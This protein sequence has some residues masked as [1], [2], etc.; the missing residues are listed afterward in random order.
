LQV[1]PGNPDA[2]PAALS[3]IRTKQN[4]AN[5]PILCN[6]VHN[7]RVIY[8][9]QNYMIWHGLFVPGSKE[10]KL[11]AVQIRPKSNMGMGYCQTMTIVHWR[12]T[13]FILIRE[14][15]NLHIVDFDDLIRKS[16][17]YGSILL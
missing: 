5:D 1:L 9:F 7:D 10:L 14:T 13:D 12:T 6:L 3:Y 17:E 8:M 4:L 16:K 15:L 2:K 11:Y